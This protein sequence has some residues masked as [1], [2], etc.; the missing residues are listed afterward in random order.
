MAK[1][2]AATVIKPRG[3]RDAFLRMNFKACLK[4]QKG[5]GNSGSIKSMF[6]VGLFLNSYGEIIR[7]GIINRIASC[8]LRMRPHPHSN[9]RPSLHDLGSCKVPA[10]DDRSDPQW[11][12]RLARESGLRFRVGIRRAAS[13]YHTKRCVR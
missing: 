6:M 11:P 9:A 12:L 13:A 3:G 5:S 2:I 8:P 1:V 4:F 10:W 7:E